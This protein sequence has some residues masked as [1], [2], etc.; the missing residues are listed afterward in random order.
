MTAPLQGV[1]PA[2]IVDYS[3]PHPWRAEI[4]RARPLILPP[5]HFIYPIEAEEVERGALEVMILPGPPDAQ[6]FLATCALGFKDPV[7]PTGIWSTPNPEEICAVAGGYAYLI[8]TTRPERFT[9]VPY[10][11]VLEV[12]PVVDFGLLLFIGHYAILAWG[13]EGEAWQSEKLSDEGISVTGTGAG[14]LSG[15]GWDLMTDTETPFTL[16]LQ[17]GLQVR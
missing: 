3:F 1:T 14:T 6:P 10:R 17:T 7:V 8:D 9:M 11:P 4:L 5:R 15:L 16:D 2:P 12:R 13:P